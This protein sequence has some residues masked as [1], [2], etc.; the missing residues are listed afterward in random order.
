MK[1]EGKRLRMK[2][3]GR[4]TDEGRRDER[5]MKR[6]MKGEGFVELVVV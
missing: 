3:E 2:G 1:R 5:W 4:E 6:E